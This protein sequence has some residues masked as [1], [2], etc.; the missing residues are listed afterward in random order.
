MSSQGWF[1]QGHKKASASVEERANWIQLELQE[2]Q[3]LPRWMS[4]AG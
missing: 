1:L 4:D 2:A 3:P